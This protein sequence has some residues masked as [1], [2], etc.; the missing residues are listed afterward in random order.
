MKNKKCIALLATLGLILCN[1]AKVEAVKFYDTVGTRY[2]G[3]VERLGEL[4]IIDGVGSKQ[5]NYSKTVTRA[6]VAKMIIELSGWEVYKGMIL[7]IDDESYSFKDV[8]EDAWYYEYVMLASK[9]GF[10]NG[11][12]DNTFRPDKEVTYKEI[13]KIFTK[14]LGH[15][16]LVETDPR[17]WEAEYTDKFR[18]IGIGDDTAYFEWDWPASRGNVAIIL[19]NT[20][21]TDVWEKIELNDYDGFTYVNSGRNLF[22]KW[23]Y[24]YMVKQDVTV[25]GFKEKNGDLYVRLG[26]TEYKV[27]DQNAVITFSMIGGNGSGLLR[28]MRYPEEQYGFELIGFSTDVGAVLNSGTFNQLKEE[29]ISLSKNQTKVGSNVDFGF[30]LNRDGEEKDRIVT[31]SGSNKFFYVEKVG[32]T[33]KNAE[34]IKDDKRDVEIIKAEVNPP[35]EYVEQV[36]TFEKIITINDSYIINDGA[37]LFRDNRRVDWST[38]KKGE[39]LTEIKKDE[40]YFVSNQTVETTV[41]GLEKGSSSIFTLNTSVDEFETYKDTKCLL[42][43]ADKVTSLSKVTKTELIGK[44]VKL[45]LDFAGRVARIEVIE[46][47]ETTDLLD[48]NIGFYKD[49]HMSNDKEEK[50]KLV[51]IS[52]KRQAIY[53]TELDYIPADFGEIIRFEYGEENS[54]LVKKTK[55]LKGTTKLTDDLTFTKEEY[56]NLETLIKN[57]DY[58]KGVIVCKATYYYDF[59]DYENIVSFDVEN[60]TLEEIAEIDE[61]KAEFFTISDKD[62]RIRAIIVKDFSNKKDMFY[63]KVINIYEKDKKLRTKLDVL[64]NGEMD[65][66]ISGS[67]NCEEGDLISFKLETRD[68]IEIHEK[69]TTKVLGYYKDLIVK[70]IKYNG[71]EAENGEIYWDD[72]KIIVGEKEYN[73]KKYVTILISL[74]KDKDGNWVIARAKQYEPEDLNLKENDRLAIDEIENTVIVYRGYKD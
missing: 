5:F 51:L 11:Y 69:F 22:N 47:D 67:P 45:M 61:E 7:G 18:E 58:A 73:L 20:L 34:T 36:K 71:I 16:Y 53:D 54:S 55:I 41:K 21:I 39:I 52:N 43:F 12:E 68:K 3:A 46:T 10:I 59:G 17:G 48:L 60:I 70:D 38:L 24:G 49:A 57:E 50:C 35:Y 42:Y 25:K 8:K 66:E 63:S 33:T 14:A 26:N 56:E 37:V 2:E 4:G 30:H 23:V 13:A 72:E 1:N 74:S 62:K 28:Y 65:F 29:D 6:E 40:Y 15:G 31:V 64:G 19:W 9:L 44:R 27:Y 32:I